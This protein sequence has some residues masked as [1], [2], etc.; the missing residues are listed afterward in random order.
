MIDI[1]QAG[2]WEIVLLLSNIFGRMRQQF[3][4]VIQCIGKLLLAIGSGHLPAPAMRIFDRAQ[5]F[6][7]LPPADNRQ[8]DQTSLGMMPDQLLTD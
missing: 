1:R 7:Q 3:P 2:D 8:F 5:Q 6:S 4:K